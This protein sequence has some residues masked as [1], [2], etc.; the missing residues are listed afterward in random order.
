MSADLLAEFGQGSAAPQTHAGQP[1]IKPPQT[2]LIDDFDQPSYESPNESAGPSHGW[3]RTSAPKVPATQ[4]IPPAPQQPPGFEFFNLPRQD[5]SDVLFDA[6]VDEPAGDDEDDWGDFEGP[7][8]TQV[9][10][11]APSVS[12]SKTQHAPIIQTSAT[13]D[14]LDSLSIADPPAKPTAKQLP[15]QTTERQHP[16]PA[17]KSQSDPGWDDNPDDDWGDFTDGPSIEPV[18]TQRTP[19]STPKPEPKPTSEIGTISPTDQAQHHQH[20][21]PSP[22]PKIS[23]KPKTKTKSVSESTTPSPNI[24]TSRT[25]VKSPENV[26]P[27]NIPPPSVLLDLLTTSLTNLQKE[28]TRAKQPSASPALKSTTA[29]AIST[30]LSTCARIIAGRQLRWKRD[31]FLAQSMRIGPAQ[32]RGMKLNTLN[33]HEDVK[34]AQDAVVVLELWRERAPLFSSIMQGA[35]LK[36][37]PVVADP[38]ALKVVTARAEQ[39]AIKASHGCALCAL[40]RDERVLRVD[41]EV[42]DSF[43]EWWTEHW[44]HTACRGFWEENKHLLS[45]R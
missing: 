22:P 17:G 29:A 32:G 5:N 25:T 2:L 21:S 13:I 10:E 24:F 6:A 1:R 44:G 40:R 14:L 39:G 35:G 34:E 45:Q 36:P 37:V 20:S 43:G 28:A 23:S 3:L 31:S 26:R 8:S 18:S 19:K 33:K 7:Q 4:A 9:A 11:P 15:S 12:V 42:N 38:G 30:T 41:E 16:T 27:T